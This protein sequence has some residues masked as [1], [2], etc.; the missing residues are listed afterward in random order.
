MNY[1]TRWISALEGTP[2]QG[3][4]FAACF[5]VFA[6][7]R[8]ADCTEKEFTENS[9]QH[10]LTMA[11][12]ADDWSIRGGVLNLFDDVDS[13][14]DDLGLANVAIQSGA[15]IFGRRF[16]VGVSKSF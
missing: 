8:V 14:D 16:F 5:D 7:A 10:D 3:N 13:V 4:A 2:D 11:Y 1:R 9:F 15:D 6:N 12:T